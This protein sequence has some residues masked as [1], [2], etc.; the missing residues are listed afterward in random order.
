[1]PNWSIIEFCVFVVWAALRWNDLQSRLSNMCR[2][3]GKL[4][5]YLKSY[6]LSIDQV[7]YNCQEFVV[8]S[9][10]YLINMKYN[11][12]LVFTTNSTLDEIHDVIKGIID[13]ITGTLDRYLLHVTYLRYN[14]PFFLFNTSF[15]MMSHFLLYFIHRF[16]ASWIIVELKSFQRSELIVDKSNCIYE[17]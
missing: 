5:S 2:L 3:L 17:A 15:F 7:A 11:D 6:F 1:M 16:W 4:V 14:V 10:L 12:N 9:N 8:L 13:E